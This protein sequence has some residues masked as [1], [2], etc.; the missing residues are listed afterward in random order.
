MLN[1]GGSRRR[2]PL[3]VGSEQTANGS[4][5]EHHQFWPSPDN[6]VNRDRELRYVFMETRETET[7][8]DPSGLRQSVNFKK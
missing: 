3:P 6:G 5:S 1:E 8:L 7:S 4:A 2:I